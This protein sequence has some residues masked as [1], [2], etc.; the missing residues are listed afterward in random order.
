MNVFQVE[1]LWIKS[2]TCLVERL[3]Q[4]AIGLDGDER[5]SLGTEIG[6]RDKSG[7]DYVAEQVD[8]DLDIVERDFALTLENPINVISPNFGRYVPLGDVANT[9][10]VLQPGCRHQGDISERSAGNNED[11]ARVSKLQQGAPSFADNS[12]GPLHRVQENSSRLSSGFNFSS[13]IGSCL[14]MVSKK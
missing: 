8:Q 12:L 1:H 11:A 5:A 2:F 7:L 13:S 10:R 3:E 9:A 4:I 6:P 14:M